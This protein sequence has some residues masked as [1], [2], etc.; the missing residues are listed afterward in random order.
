[1]SRVLVIDN[2]DSFCYNLVQYL[3]QLGTEPVTLRN[4]AI[5]LDDAE[6]L[7]PTHIVISPGPGHPETAGVSSDIIRHFG[8]QGIPILGVC[9]GHQ[10]IAMTFGGSIQ[11]SPV[12]VHGKTSEVFHDGATLYNDIPSPFTATRY[13]SLEVAPD[14]PSCLKVCARTREGAVMGIRHRQFQ[15]E[16]VQ[17]HPESILTQ[18]GMAMLRNFLS[19]EKGGP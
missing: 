15:V 1:M 13:H 14:L 7:N 8:P 3:G 6:S 17:F 4:D 10:A 11:K 9:L 12:P 18:M 2:Y 19:Q 16:G 5:H